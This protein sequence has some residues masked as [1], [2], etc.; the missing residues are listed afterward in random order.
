QSALKKAQLDLTRT[1][2]RAPFNAMV[3]TESVDAGQL[4]SPQGTVARLVGTD[5]YHVQVSV[6]VASLRTVRA[7]TDDAPGS[8][9][10]I[11]QYVGQ[12]TIERR[13][14][15]IRQLPDLDP[16]GAMARILV[17]IENPLGNPGDLPLLLGSFVD[18]EVGAQP[19]EDAIRV[20]RV[21]LRN[22]RSVYVM[23]DDDQLEIRDV[24][25]AWTEPD[26]VLVTRGLE[27]NERVVTSRIPT[28]VPNM[29][30][31]TLAEK[32]EAAPGDPSKPAAQAT[33]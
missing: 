17:R 32:P 5:E 24:Q 28:P 21:A 18:V 23:N 16:G 9:T 33:P 26:A 2:L 29:L 22:G 13:G 25:I 27:S 12:E 19:I 10:K 14:E 3:V 20:P 30:L 8:E 4:V 6:P 15:V 11:I 7:R 1:T 31:R